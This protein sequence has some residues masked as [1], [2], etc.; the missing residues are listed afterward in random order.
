MKYY[1]LIGVLGAVLAYPFIAFSIILTP[2][3]N[4]YDNALSDLGNIAWNAPVAY[5]YNTGLVLSGLLV[6]FF[7]LLTS[8][9]HRSWK[10]LSWSLLLML[11]GIDLALIGV[12][13][14]DAGGIHGL[15]SVIF[16]TM[17]IIVMLVYFFCSL[18]LK[19][20]F[21]GVLS[22]ILSIASAIV[23]IVEWGWKG[24]AIQETV[25]SLMATVWL[26]RVSLEAR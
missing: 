16:F 24:V 14:E 20:Y 1:R 6:A 15:V 12:F 21:T 26:L 5:L 9:K 19:N 23:W 4:F 25:T 18:V 7:A 8:L 3:F 11:I 22:L 10:Y 2:W 17:M 13:P